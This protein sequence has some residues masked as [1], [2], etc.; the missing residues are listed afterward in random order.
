MALSCL[1][2]YIPSLSSDSM[3]ET[4]LNNEDKFTATFGKDIEGTRATE[5]ALD[6]VLERTKKV[7]YSNP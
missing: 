4:I 6:L 2:A 7:E 1:H 3:R 5:A